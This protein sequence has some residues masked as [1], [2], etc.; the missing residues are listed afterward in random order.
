MGRHA[1]RH[2]GGHQRHVQ[3]QDYQQALSPGH[4]WRSHES[5]ILKT[6]YRLCREAQ[7]RMLGNG[8]CTRPPDLDCRLESA[9]KTCAYFRIGT[10]FLPILARQRDHAR[11][12]EQPDRAEL[13]STI[14]Q[15]V[16]QAP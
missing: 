1:H 4:V 11:G 2:Q 3:C 12:H 15:N 5:A 7:A 6:A 9:C 13:F 8:V 10:E 16:E 14:I